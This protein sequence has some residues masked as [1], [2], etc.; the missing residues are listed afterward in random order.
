MAPVTRKRALASLFKA[1]LLFHVPT[2]LTVSYPVTSAEVE[3]SRSVVC[4]GL[5]RRCLRSGDGFAD[6]PVL[7]NREA[8]MDDTHDN[9]PHAFTHAH[10]LILSFTLHIF[11][12]SYLHIYFCIRIYVHIHICTPCAHQLMQVYFH[13]CTCT[14]GLAHRQKYMLY[15]D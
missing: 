2:G 8:G 3:G 9:A 13:K 4:R 1:V 12:H 15:S 14:L 6:R 10:K 11:L 5:F 7:G